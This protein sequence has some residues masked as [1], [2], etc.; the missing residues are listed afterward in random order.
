MQIV[1]FRRWLLGAYA[2]DGFRALRFG[3]V[4]LRFGVSRVGLPWGKPR[5]AWAYDHG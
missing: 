2:V 5:R 3:P 1:L 4:E